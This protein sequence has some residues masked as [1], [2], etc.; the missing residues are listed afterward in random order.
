MYIDSLSLSMKHETNN[1]KYVFQN[2]ACTCTINARKEQPKRLLWKKVSRFPVKKS[3]RKIILGTFKIMVMTKT[4]RHIGFSKFTNHHWWYG[5][6]SI[7]NPIKFSVFVVESAAVSK[8]NSTNISHL[9]CLPF[10]RSPPVVRLTPYRLGRPSLGKNHGVV[11]SHQSPGGRTETE[12]R[13]QNLGKEAKGGSR[14]LCVLD[15]HRRGEGFWIFE[16]VFC[17]LCV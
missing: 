1:L 9:P 5:A 3:C 7:L 13:G 15:F 17:F 2:A 6:H 8:E 10:A 11:E 4:V 12:K 16:I 14:V